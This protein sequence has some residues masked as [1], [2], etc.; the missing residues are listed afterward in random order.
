MILGVERLGEQIHGPGLHGLD[1]RWDVGVAGDED[2]RQPAARGR[3]HLLQLDPGQARHPH[4]QHEAARAGVLG[5]REELPSRGER[6]DQVAGRPQQSSQALPDGEVVIHDEDERRDS[7]HR[8]PSASTGSASDD[9]HCLFPRR[10][11]P[12]AGSSRL[13]SVL[14]LTAPL[15]HRLLDFGPILRKSIGNAASTAEASGAHGGEPDEINSSR[16]SLVS[17]LF[18]HPDP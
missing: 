18:G 13:P 5:V 2:D 15:D 8:A 3:Q 7:R 6:L 9:R 4:V 17:L 11:C 14:T 16:R 12:I 10:A 1:A